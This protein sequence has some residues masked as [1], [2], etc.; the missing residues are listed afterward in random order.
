MRASVAVAVAAA[1]AI[2]AM[3]AGSVDASSAAPASVSPVRLAILVPQVPADATR[4]GPLPSE[5]QLTIDVVLRPSHSRQLSA[6]LDDLADPTSRRYQHW[7]TPGEFTREF[8]PNRAQVER[9]TSWLHTQGL[10]ETSLRGMAVHATGDAQAVAQAFGVTFSRYRLSRAVTGYL[11]SAAPTVPRTVADDIATVVGLSDTVRFG[12]ALDRT[13]HTTLRPHPTDRPVSPAA[14]TACPQATSFADESYWT[15]DQVGRSYH[16]NDLWADGLTG[17]G[18]TIA[19][20]EL[21]QSRAADTNQYFSCFGLHNAVTVK[22][23]DGGA[24]VGLGGSLEAEIDIQEAATQAPGASIVSYE[25]PNTA[26]GVYDA[27]NQIVQDDRAQVVS[28]SWG[29]CEAELTDASLDALH[30]LFQQAAAQGQTVFAATGDSGSEDCYQGVKTAHG[31]M[32]QVDNPADDPLVTGVGGTALENLGVEPVWNDCEGETGDSCAGNGGGAGGGGL[33]DHFQRPSWQ[34]LAAD[35]TCSTCREVPDIS[36]N[37]GV[38]ETFYFLGGWT[39]VGGT[40][41]AAPKMAGITAD[42][43][44][45]CD[46]GSLGDFAAKVAAL[47]SKHTYGT[48][49]VDVNTGINW[50]TF[51]VETPGSNDLTR[52]HAGTFRTAPGFDLATGFGVPIASGLA[53]PQIATMTP[54]TG[55]AG[56][57]VT[58][59]GVGLE[60]TTITFG[61]ATA[62]VVS[63][64]PTTEVVIAPAGTGTVNVAGTDPI[65]TGDQPAPFTYQTTPAG[66]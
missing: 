17:N 66:P 8:G 29:I 56:T 55:H 51:A 14:V 28:T 62:Q 23:V 43:D 37:A 31:E 38:G 63:A 53:C 50:T 7:L 40:S 57:R 49:V 15:P 34:P 16:V 27:Y 32:L 25:A 22:K 9:V 10:S 48:A 4:L 54:N 12:H 2:V 46:A 33:S 11:A 59:H 41:I 42:I 30:G 24:S 64:S 19:V 6:L 3:L 13:P 1:L 5:Q 36:A 60:R 65:G 44:Q 61:T 58:L 47:I 20:F 39:A 52:T 45:G 35:A 26:V 21:A 18:K